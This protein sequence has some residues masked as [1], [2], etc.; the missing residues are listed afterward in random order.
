MKEPQPV[1]FPLN[2]E[3]PLRPTTVLYLHTDNRLSAKLCVYK[4]T[5][6]ASAGQPTITLDDARAKITDEVLMLELQQD[7]WY[8]RT[9][10]AV[11]DSGAFVAEIS[12]PLLALGQWKLTFPGESTHSSH[13]IELRP[14][15]MGR[16]EDVFVK[17]SVPYF[18][19]LVDSGAVCKLFKVVNGRRV[20]V[21]RYTG[22]RRGRPNGIL[23]VD[24]RQVDVVVTTMT[25][26]AVL[27]RS[28]SFRK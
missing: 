12:G 11:D 15:G 24:D 18:W 26:A 28:D 1:D 23:E 3:S 16:R 19:D 17:D 2:D 14:V 21:G 6:D 10:R 13:A 8:T 9:L 22:K 4:I 7:A 5:D 27:K 25:C 20:E